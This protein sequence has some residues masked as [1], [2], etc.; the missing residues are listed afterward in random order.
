MIHLNDYMI[1]TK[2]SMAP[3]EFCLTPHDMYFR[4]SLVCHRQQY[5][6]VY[7]PQIHSLQSEVSVR[8]FDQI[9]IC[10]AMK[11]C[12][13]T[14]VLSFAEHGDASQNNVLYTLQRSCG[15]P[16]MEN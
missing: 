1:Q 2:V 8:S 11:T 16:E 13:L 3:T 12:Q 6:G 4:E 15:N 14:V 7:I 5:N 9:C 10:C